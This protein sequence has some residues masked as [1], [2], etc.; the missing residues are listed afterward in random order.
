MDRM[1]GAV[2]GA[3]RTRGVRQENR[4]AAT[5]KVSRARGSNGNRIAVV[6]GANV[7]SM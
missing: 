4:K 3:K 7:T 6:R 5:G 2:G 1:A